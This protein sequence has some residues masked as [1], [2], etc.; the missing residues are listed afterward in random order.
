MHGTSH[1]LGIDVHDFTL[2]EWTFAVG[3]GTCEPGIYILAE[4][5][6]YRMKNDIW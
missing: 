1:H 6:R 2:D 3:N 5:F 4:G